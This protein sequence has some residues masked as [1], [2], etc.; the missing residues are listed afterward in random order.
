MR[1]PTVADDRLMRAVR[2][3]QRSRIR[4]LLAYSPTPL[5]GELVVFRGERDD[6]D[7][8]NLG[9]HDFAT[10]GIELHAIEGRHESVLDEPQV[11][12]LAT[13]LNDCLDRSGL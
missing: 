1:T 4:A 6:D 10:G 2:D 3:V 13:E 7:I 12:T 5:P 8:P 9:W 11:S